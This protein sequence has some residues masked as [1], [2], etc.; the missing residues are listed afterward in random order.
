MT[1]EMYAVKSDESFE[2]FREKIK[3]NFRRM[4][5]TDSEDEIYHLRKTNE[6]LAIF[7]INSTRIVQFSCDSEES[8]QERLSEIKKLTGIKLIKHSQIIN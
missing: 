3:S 7:G 5:G 1:P 6:F 2:T 8:H 4:N